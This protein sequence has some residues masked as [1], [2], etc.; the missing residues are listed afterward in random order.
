M[1]KNKQA[2]LANLFLERDP[3]YQE[4]KKMEDHEEWTQLQRLQIEN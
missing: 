4:V 2:R 3:K 1:K